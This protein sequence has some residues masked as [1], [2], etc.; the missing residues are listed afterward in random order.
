MADM[1][2]DRFGE[3]AVDPMKAFIRE[4]QTIS[5]VI[6]ALGRI[7]DEPGMV[8]FLIETLQNYSPQ[9]HRSMSARL[10]LVDALADYKHPDVVPAVFPYLLDHDDDIRIKVMDIVSER[11]ERNGEN[12]AGLLDGLV[13]VLLDPMASGRV[14]RKAASILNDL[15]A[16]LSK[17]YDELSD[18]VPDGFNLGTN[19][20]LRPA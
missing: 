10:Q 5:S 1:L 7:V 9:D 12:Y 16:D 6:M 3:E 14:T 4:D 8:S 13:S 11:V 2:V 20:R 19:G 17:R 18:Y 15:D